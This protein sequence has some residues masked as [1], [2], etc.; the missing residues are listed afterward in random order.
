MLVIKN[1]LFGDSIH[2]TRKIQKAL[3]VASKEIVLKVNAEKI[4]YMFT[5]HMQ[6]AGENHNSTKTR[7]QFFNPLKSVAKFKALAKTP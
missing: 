3:L 2:I 1:S 7:N 4:K 6:N 5:C